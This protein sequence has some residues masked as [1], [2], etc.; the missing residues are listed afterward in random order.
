MD[1]TKLLF[2]LGYIFLSINADI[3]SNRPSTRDQNGCLFTKGYSWCE[4]LQR[5]IRLWETPCK[6]NYN[7]CGECLFRQHL[8]S[9]ACP[10]EC[11]ILNDIPCDLCPPEPSCSL[12]GPDCEYEQQ[13]DNC[14]CLRECGNIVCDSTIDPVVLPPNPCPIKQIDCINEFVCPKITEITHCTDGG[15]EGHTTYQLSL[16]VQ[17][18][19]Y[20]KNIYALFGDNFHRDMYIPPAYQIDGPFDSN[21][22]GISSSIISIFPD[23]LYDSWLTIGISDGDNDNKLSTI[24]IDFNEWSE[25]KPITTSNGA[26][27]SLDP[28]EG[29]NKNEYIV[30]Q[31]TIRD[32]LIDVMTVNVQ[33]KKNNNEIWNEY[34][35]DFVLNPSELVRKDIPDSCLLWF[36]GCNL[37]QVNHGSLSTCTKNMCFTE[38]KSECRVYSPSGH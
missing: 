22:G 14:G 27:F 26:V 36:D 17:P 32:N 20:I 10:P 35:I 21:I 19:K 33:G 18:N 15:I 34:D 2:N 28:N 31:I 37:C 5:C 16:V 29:E 8:E 30:G 11:S 23:A 1:L 3:M 12:P 6:D 4:D 24:G 25:I 38:S 9:I 7:N 13:R